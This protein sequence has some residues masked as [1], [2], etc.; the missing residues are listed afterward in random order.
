MNSIRHVILDVDG[1]CVHAFR[2][3]PWLTREHGIETAAPSAFFRGPFRECIV[4]KAD[5]REALAPFAAEWR[6]PSDLD[7][8]IV[9]WFRRDGQVEPA[10]LGAAARLRARGVPVHLASNQE[11]Y[12]ARCLESVLGFAE[13]FDRR[14]FSCDLGVAKPD[15]TFYA[16]VVRELE[17]GAILFFDDHAANVDAAR[18]AGWR[19]EI[20]TDVCSLYEHLARHLGDHGLEPA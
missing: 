14:F 9:E 4:G 10:V 16:Q 2:F 5:L 18:A 17:P 6:V 20:Y 7:A 1:V 12:R 11:R 15:E 8:L 19:A 3:G 13:R